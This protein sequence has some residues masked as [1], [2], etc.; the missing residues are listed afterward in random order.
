MREN[1]S[2]IKNSK[3]L[4]SLPFGTKEAKLRIS[5]TY[6]QQKNKNISMKH[7]QDLADL[8]RKEDEQS[9][10]TEQYLVEEA[11]QSE[12]DDWCYVNSAERGNHLPCCN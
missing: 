9:L 4:H 6:T 5:T 3:Y 12:P 7:S 11:N 8:L 1:F 2:L 10:R